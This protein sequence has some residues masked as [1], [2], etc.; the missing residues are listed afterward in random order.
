MKNR[1]VSEM[2]AMALLFYQNAN[3]PS[4]IVCLTKQET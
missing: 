4:I 1:I 2:A 3:V